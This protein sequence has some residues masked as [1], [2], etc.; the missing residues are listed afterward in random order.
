MTDGFPELLNSEGDPLGY[1]AVDEQFALHA[2]GVNSAEVISSLSAA[3]EAW[4]GGLPP[5][6]DITFV[7]VRIT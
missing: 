7:V 4:S 1:V 2:A 3:A 6:D 5:N